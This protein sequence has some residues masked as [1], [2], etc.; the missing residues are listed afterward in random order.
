MTDYITLRQ[1]IANE[2][3]QAG[4]I[5]NR[6]KEKVTDIEQQLTRALEYLDSSHETA[7]EE[8]LKLNNI[9]QQNVEKENQINQL[10][11]EIKSLEESI[12]QI[13][14]ERKTEEEKITEGKKQIETTKTELERKSEELKKVKQEIEHTKEAIQAKENQIK[15]QE[16]I[17]EREEQKAKK[18]IEELEKEEQKTVNV[19]PV[20][21]YLLKNVRIDIPEVDILSTLAYRNKEIGLDD[22][23]KS[24]ANTQPV[25][26]LKVLRKL[27]S[28]GIVEYNERL[29]TIKLAVE[30][31]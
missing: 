15:N 21:D 12:E 5:A 10:K 18:L 28:L 24:V 27:D 8:E 29:D 26:I 6:V 14:T 7:K 25:I 31:V 30:L 19:S 22:L 4:Q 16:Q 3:T 1:K 13:T 11:T 17:N 20:L 23:K 9:Q 2:K